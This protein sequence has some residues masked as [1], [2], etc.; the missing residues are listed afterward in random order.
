MYLTNRCRI[1]SRT[2]GGSRNP[3][4]RLERPDNP[5]FY[6]RV[7]EGIVKLIRSDGHVHGFNLLSVMHL[8][9]IVI[10]FHP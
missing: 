5:E 8:C 10:S 3:S 1:P 9:F 7:I 4:R 2:R 6:R